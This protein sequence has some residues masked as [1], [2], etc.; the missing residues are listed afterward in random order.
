MKED[1]PS[2]LKAFGELSSISVDLL[3]LCCSSRD[4][5]RIH[6]KKL[7][8]TLVLNAFCTFV[9]SVSCHS[10]VIKF[11]QLL[12][13][14]VS[15]CDAALKFITEVLNTAA[16]GIKTWLDYIQQPNIAEFRYISKD[17]STVIV[18]GP[19]EELLVGIFNI[20][21]M[22]IIIICVDS[23]HTSFVLSYHRSVLNHNR[24]FRFINF[25]LYV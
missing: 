14:F 21:I 13:Q 24:M 22:T 17:K 19:S 2:N 20:I 18:R 3:Q 4:L 9:L 23:T 15:E 1:F 5:S 10:D 11:G 16:T 7:L 8:S 25:R 6:D 12:K